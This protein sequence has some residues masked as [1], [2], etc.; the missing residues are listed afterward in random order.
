MEFRALNIYARC[1]GESL[2]EK[3]N[4]A[5]HQTIINMHL[6]HHMGEF[7]DDEHFLMATYKM[8]IYVA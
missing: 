3:I 7:M 5:M 6:A 8:N 2:Q 1:V 4:L